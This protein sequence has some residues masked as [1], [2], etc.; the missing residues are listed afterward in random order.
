LG[1]DVPN[2]K[3]K[4]LPLGLAIALLE[5]SDD[6]IDITIN[7]AGNVD[8]PQFSASGLVWQAI[9]NV[10]TNVATAPFRALGALLGMSSNDGVNAVLGQAVYLAPDQDRLEKFGDFLAKRPNA[11]LVLVGTYDPEVDKAALALATADLAILKAAGLSNLPNELISRPDFS[12]PKVLSGLK[13][14]Y[15]QY[16]GTIKLGQRLITLPEGD[17]RNEQLYSELIASISITEED[18][19]TLAKNRAK[20]AQN[21]MVKNNP[22]LI[23]RISLGEVKT[24]ATNKEGVPLEVEVRI[25]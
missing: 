17:A 16:I 15:S 25:K 5:D 4:K 22:E 24:I 13:S 3:G 7:I 12:Y 1:E 10:L 8:S 20:L 21:L 11:S 2:F 14:V 9:S 6:T 18:L 19:K 23:D